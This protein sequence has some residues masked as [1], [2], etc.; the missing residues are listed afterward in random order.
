MFGPEG[1]PIGD[2]AEDQKCADTEKKI[3]RVLDTVD[4][5]KKA[6]ADKSKDFRS[7]LKQE[8]TTGAAPPKEG[9][10]QADVMIL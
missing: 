4:P 8:K 7:F 2:S 3:Q 9:A 6:K 5:P 10:Q 1:Q